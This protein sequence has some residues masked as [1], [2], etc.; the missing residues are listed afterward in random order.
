MWAF[1]SHR[2]SFDLAEDK[3]ILLH[4]SLAF[5][6]VVRHFQGCVKLEVDLLLLVRSHQIRVYIK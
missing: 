1:G 5:D 2:W 3:R 6:W 4:C